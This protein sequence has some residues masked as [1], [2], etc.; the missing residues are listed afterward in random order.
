MIDRIAKDEF[1]TSA[2]LAQN[3]LLYAAIRD[4]KLFVKKHKM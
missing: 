1:G 3:R 2:P 4:L